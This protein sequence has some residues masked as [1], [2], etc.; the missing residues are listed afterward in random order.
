VTGVQALGLLAAWLLGGIPFG[1]LAGLS[2]G[3]DVRKA[4]SG[5][6]GAT[7][8][9]RVVGVKLGLL[10]FLLDMLKGLAGVMICRALGMEGWLLPTA[11]LITVM[12]HSFSP[13]LLFKGGKGVATA[14]GVIIGVHPLSAAVCFGVWLLVTVLTRYVSL[15]S[16]LG[17]LP[18][19]VL[20]YLL[21][22]SHNAE[23]AVAFV[24]LCLLVVGRHAENIER[25]MK[26]T[27]SRF[28]SKRKPA[29]EE[30]SDTVGGAD[31]GDD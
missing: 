13:Y 29:D 5:N 2:R 30:T 22:P 4:G 24:P 31:T 14:L 26:G 11:G 3:V 7:N 18:A 23:L 6:I 21:A 8:V 28:G 12:G 10:V 20:V 19:P 17:V 27:E 9:I 15:A 25:L 1:L 16:V